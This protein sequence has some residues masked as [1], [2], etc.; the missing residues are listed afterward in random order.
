MSNPGSARSWLRYGGVLVLW[1]LVGLAF[2]SQFYLS[3]S[4]IGR[5][6]TW[7]EA[8]SY[9]LGDWYVWAVLSVPI[10]LLARMYPP[11][12]A[13]PLRVG[14]IHLGAALAISLTYVVLRALVGQAHGWLIDEPVAFADVFRSL[15]VKTFP[16]NLLVYGVILSASH[17]LD[18]YRKYHERTVHALELEK[19][20]TEA[21]LQALLRQL[22]PHFLFNTLNGIASLMH[23]DV[24][25]ADRMLVRLSELLRLTMNQS[26]QPMTRL[27]DEVAFI[28]K[29]LDIERIRFRDRF[30]VSIEI[31]PAVRDWP[32]PSL[33]LQPLVE[34]AIRHGVEPLKSGGRIVVRAQRRDERLE[35][36]VADNGVGMPAEGF[37]REGIG[38]ANT[39]SRLRELYGDAQVFELGHASAAGGLQVKLILPAQPT[40]AGYTPTDS[41]ASDPDGQTAHSDRR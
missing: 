36:I 20:L 28:E 5:S 13:R 39:R 10:V 23:S 2:A 29:Y 11:D 3:S 33:V 24:D 12:E 30:T 4:L 1:T 40:A 32:V 22:K 7:T 21:R 34:N 9:S 8:I 15:L 31:D 6:V 14:L 16:F 17:A 27:R 35:L 19:H 41:F 37:S 26:G 38:V 25:A 18:Y